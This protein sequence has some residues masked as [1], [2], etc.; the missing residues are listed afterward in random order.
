MKALLKL[1]IVTFLLTSVLSC[2]DSPDEPWRPSTAYEI[3]KMPL[4][5]SGTERVKLKIPI[6][7]IA[8]VS[9]YWSAS[10]QAEYK[11]FKD[12]INKAFDQVKKKSPPKKKTLSTVLGLDTVYPSFEPK[13][14]E[15]LH[16]FQGKK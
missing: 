2:S 8:P 6:G 4:N 7:Y 9:S 15:N 1:S 11:P 10:E 16:L 12:A 3:M 14:V 13:S 5:K